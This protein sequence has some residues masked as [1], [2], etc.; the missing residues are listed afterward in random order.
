MKWSTTTVMFI[1]TGL[2]Y[3]KTNENTIVA[4]Q[5]CNKPTID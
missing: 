2:K 1:S 4:Q 3:L 5:L